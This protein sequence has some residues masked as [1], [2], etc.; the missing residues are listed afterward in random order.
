MSGP[1]T[2]PPP[3]FEAISTDER[4][5]IV[6]NPSSQSGKAALRFEPVRELLD[7]YK[8]TYSMRP[9]TPDGKTVERVS[10]AIVEEGFRTIVYL[11]G[12]GTFSDVAKGTCQSGKA[13]EVR[14]GMLPAGTA[15]DQGKSF[16]IASTQKAIEDNVRII[17]AGKTT[18]L[19][20]GEVTAWSDSGIVQ[21]RDLF[22]DSAGWGLSAAILSYRNQ[23]REIVNKLPV[24]RDM[25][26]DQMVYVRAAVRELALSWVTRDRFTAIAEIDGKTHIMDR[27]SDLVVS[28]TAVYAG[29]W[30]V[31]AE[32]EH[33]D[34]MLEIAPFH[35]VRDWTSKLIMHHKKVPLTEE[36]VNRIGVSHSP[37][38]R[39]SVIKIKFI[40]LGKNKKLLAQLDGEEF[41]SADH[42]EICVHKRLLNL[43][44]PENF[45]WI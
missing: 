23:E 12:D 37:T 17:A 43:I 38:L 26:R 3:P 35:G 29:E 9:T 27:L 10:R 8:I 28:N 32:S 24:V 44:V 16:G 7:K 13:R 41:L 30:V 36:M 6:A 18:Q 25:Y 22:F 2:I 20:V 42:F 31:D 33:D 15:N 4:V 40:K 1:S 14:I 21:R 39:G 11:G 45:H 34:G 5:L 19:D